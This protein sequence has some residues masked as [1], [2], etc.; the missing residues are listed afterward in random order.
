MMSRNMWAVGVNNGKLLLVTEVLRSNR[1]EGGFYLRHLPG[2]LPRMLGALVEPEW[3][4]TELRRLLDEAEQLDV[5]E[6]RDLPLS[7]T[8]NFAEERPTCRCG[9]ERR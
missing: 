6:S 7:S 3:D 4:F 1:R 8:T 5:L 2:E 9:T